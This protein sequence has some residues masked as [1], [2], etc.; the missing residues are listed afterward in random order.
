M[1]LRLRRLATILLPIALVL[2]MVTQ[3]QASSTAVPAA[4]GSVS[5]GLADPGR[6]LP[7]GWQRSPDR[8]MTVQGDAAGLHVLVADEA[9]GYQW[10]TAATLGDPGVETS[11]WIGQACL[12]S[13][14]D[15]GVVVYAPRQVTN[16]GGAMGI[17][18]RAA[19]VDLR[20]GSVR[21]LGVGYSVA[22]FDPGCGAG[23]QAV[24]TGSGWGEDGS[25]N[26]SST[27]LRL[28][29]VAT[30]SAALSVTVPGQA[31]SAVPYDGA[32]AA[33]YGK[34]L[35]EISTGGHVRLLATTAGIPFRLAP[36][37]AGGLGFE[38]LAAKTVELS[39][40]ATGRSSQVGSGPVGT[41]QLDGQ[42]GRVWVTGSTAPALRA[43]PS[44]WHAVN[45]PAGSQVSTTGALAVTGAVATPPADPRRQQPDEP[46]PVQLQAQLLTGA[47]QHV[48]FTVPASSP[49]T[50]LPDSQAGGSQS[51]RV[52]PQTADSSS[53][54]VSLDRTCAVARNDP[55]IQAYQPDFAQVEWAADQAVQGTLTD[56]RPAGLYGSSLPS[57]SPQGLF[58]LPSLAGG[59][60]IPAQ[61]L[62]GVLTQESNL[63]QASTHVI[64]G[65]ASNPLTSFNWYGTWANGGT[66]YTGYINWANADCGYGIGQITTGMCAQLDAGGDPQCE[67]LPLDGTH[68]LAIAVDYQANIAAA[69]QMLA[70]AWNQLQ[71]AGITMNSGVP[72]SA[73]YIDNWYLAI[74]AYNSGVEPA[75][76]EYG[77]T[78]GCTPG[79]SC[80]DGNGDWGLGYAN[81]PANP[82]YPPD[83][84]VFPGPSS[85]PGP[86]GA[87]YMLNWDLSHPQ[88]WTYQEKVTSWAF[89]SVTLWDYNQGKAVQAFAYANGTAEYPPTSDLCTS[90]NH[91]D[92]SVLGSS[93]ATS[94]GDACQ[95]S[96]NYADHCWWH[97]PV[98]WSGNC[99]SA[100]GGCGTSVL[101]YSQGAAAPAN[102]SIATQ[103]QPE[104]SIGESNAVIVGGGQSV[105]GCPGQNWT[106]AGSL[107]WNFA[108]DPNGTYLSKINFDQ[109]G[110]G[111][112]GHFWFGYTIANDGSSITSTTPNSVYADQEI[113]GTW[114]APSSVAGWAQ[115]FVHIP[116][117]GAWDPQA[118]Y[119]INLGGGQGTQHRVINQAW[120]VNAWLPLG[121]YNLGSGASVSLSNVTYSGL[122]RDI[123]WNAVAFVPSAAPSQ[124]YVAMGDSYSSGEGLS[125]YETA[126][127]YKYDGMVDACHRS[128]FGGAEQAY[129]ALV[130]VPGTTQKFFQQA[131]VAGSGVQANFLACSGEFSSEM[132]ESAL[133]SP[134]VG[135]YNTFGVVQQAPMANTPWAGPQ[136]GTGGLISLAY[137]ET[138]QVDVGALN[139]QTT[140]V[141]LNAGGDDVR[142]APVLTACV[143]ATLGLGPNCLTSNL[144]SDPAPLQQYEPEVI[145][146]LEPHLVQLYTDIAARAPNAMIIVVGYPELFEDG[147]SAQPGCQNA[148]LS[149]DQ[150]SWMN[151][152]GQLL[153]QE[154]G[155]A[156]DAVQ[157]QGLDFYFIPP[158]NPFGNGTSP[159]TGHRVCDP[160]TGNAPADPYINGLVG[161]QNTGSGF[162]L[163]AG[164]FH[165]TAA[166]EQEYATLVNQ[167]VQ[168]QLPMCTSNP[169]VGAAARRIQ[170][171]GK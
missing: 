27:D 46:L 74:W 91:C 95:L 148:L 129:A 7:A 141:T 78:T 49:A 73:N 16:M 34:G 164:S 44:G 13:D 86:G 136:P 122:G 137:N 29:D 12:S 119:Q 162:Q 22:Y 171:K 69:A 1:S 19:I 131:T 102:P 62:L 64:Q 59:G 144:G 116:S 114:S 160:T 39:R 150:T 90:A 149:G 75:T 60:S 65:Q 134:S 105:L 30:G 156:V 138:P 3:A 11:Q 15:Y 163:V 127:D 83:R 33:A 61:V 31:T 52:R 140:L 25:T 67:A 45:V 135:G 101:T 130:D 50:P 117:Y 161:P 82:A 51:A 47:H 87:T 57:Y 142:F 18:G 92:T 165:P 110:A 111:F 71:E 53:T 152:M 84:P 66:N 23:D 36:D 80:T 139:S 97:Q 113:T 37:S 8:I 168:G 10:R 35:S 121:L 120:Q 76:S 54:P 24:L 17:L 147:T 169:F 4:P 155:D 133:D 58:P 21:Q 6:M 128:G 48:T 126:S 143:K 99:V 166:G 104:C 68:Q 153:N 167:C 96:G 88:Y 26:S 109:I 56:T 81:N 70:K 115:I 98:T 41:L 77:N 112:G 132:D 103:F 2:G 55:S 42:G 123:A 145:Q 9:S 43:M 154:I 14:S 170:G 79:A 5:A 106:S 20:S 159:F 85:A 38:T 94:N 118:N 108:A 124:S 146:A 32:I 28:V 40:F 107:T 93:S 63:D 151:G 158:D 100:S 157:A 89:D 72:N 125:P